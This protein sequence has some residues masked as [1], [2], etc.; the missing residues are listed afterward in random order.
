M[1]V[2]VDFIAYATWNSTLGFYVPTTI[3]ALAGFYPDATE[4][5]PACFSVTLHQDWITYQTHESDLAVVEFLCGAPGDVTGWIP[6]AVAADYDINYTS[7][8]FLGGYDVSGLLPNP[9]IG[10]RQYYPGSMLLR[11]GPI[12][13]VWTIGPRLYHTMDTSGGVSGGGMLMNVFSDLTGGQNPGFYWV[14]TSSAE[15]TF[16]NTGRKNDLLT[17]QWIAAATS[18]W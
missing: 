9:N 6:G 5:T 16:E 10:T 12:G 1:D 2:G 15:G 11:F 3:A 7:S 18:E 14:G 8:T 13:D 17:W 4:T